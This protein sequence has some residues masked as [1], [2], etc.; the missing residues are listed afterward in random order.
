MKKATCF[1]CH[2]SDATFN[3]CRHPEVIK[4]WDVYLEQLKK[5]KSEHE[6]W[7]D[8]DVLGLPNKPIIEIKKPEID[9]TIPNKY[10]ASCGRHDHRANHLP[11]Y[12]Q[13]LE[14]QIAFLKEKLLKLEENPD[15]F[16]FEGLPNPFCTELR[17]GAREVNWRT[18]DGV[19]ISYMLTAGGY[20][21]RLFNVDMFNR[22]NASYY[23]TSIEELIDE[24]I[25][26]M[27][28]YVRPQRLRVKQEPN[29]PHAW[30]LFT[31]GN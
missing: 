31:N 28:H 1:N 5:Q 2:H 6:I 24:A 29:A 15:H 18:G 25:D 13:P 22:P 20:Q 17:F 9:P 27:A 7:C 10:T 16:T 11:E 23:T 19:G 26:R 30:Y 3:K 4:E 21:Y 14:E 12:C 8:N